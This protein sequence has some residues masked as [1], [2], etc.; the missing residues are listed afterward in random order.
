MEFVESSVATP[1]PRK[2]LSKTAATLLA[3]TGGIGVGLTVVCASFVA[4][5][6]R[7]YCLPYVPA[8]NQQISNVLSVV[9]KNMQGKLLDIGSGDGRIV[10]GEMCLFL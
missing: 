5:A 6:F 8:T 9:P 10:L 4:P 2:K 3:L 1:A 7:K